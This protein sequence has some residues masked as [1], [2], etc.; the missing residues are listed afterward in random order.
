MV[1]YIVDI[2]LVLYALEYIWKWSYIRTQRALAVGVSED[3]TNE[4]YEN[5]KDMDTQVQDTIDDMLSSISGSDSDVVS[6]V[7]DKNENVKDVQFVIKTTAIK[8]AEQEAVQEDE[9][10]EMN[11]WQKLVNLF[12]K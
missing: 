6:F 12:K 3:G 10:V 8:K 2:L 5:T 11:F 4:F 1:S 7:S 9:E